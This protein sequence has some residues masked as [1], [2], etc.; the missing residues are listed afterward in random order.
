MVHDMEN[1]ARSP[2]RT[3]VTDS[4]LLAAVPAMAYVLAFAFEYGYYFAY[5]FPQELISVDLNRVFVAGAVF[6]AGILLLLVPASIVLALLPSDYP[7]APAI[8]QA[9][10]FT[11]AYLVFL[12]YYWRFDV[13]AWILGLLLLWY[14][15]Y[16]FGLPLTQRGVHGYLQ[17]YHKF[18]QTRQGRTT[19]FRT[20][21]RVLSPIQSTIVIYFFV[22]IVLAISFGW[23]LAREQEHYFVVPGSPERVVLRIYGDSIILAPF[24]RHTRTIL[25]EYTVVRRTV[26]AITLRVERVGPLTLA[27]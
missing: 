27:H 13:I 7:L 12:V 15:G 11:L 22:A 17:K 23:S 14:L 16:K 24:D 18:E 4:V 19:L 10:T 6:L 9:A 1:P 26:G 3:W 2:R 25:P 20:A 8:A 21:L 5:G